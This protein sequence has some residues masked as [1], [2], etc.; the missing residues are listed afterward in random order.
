MIEARNRSKVTRA[1]SHALQSGAGI[2]REQTSRGCAS[3]NADPAETERFMIFEGVIQWTQAVALQSDRVAAAQAA[4]FR[5]GG[6]G[7]HR[8]PGMNFRSECDYFTVAVDM[9]FQFKK[10]ADDLGLFAS[11]DF[12]EID[13]VPRQDR[14]D[15]R[16]KRLHVTEYFKPGGESGK[17]W[18]IETAD[19]KADASATHGTLI[20]GRLDWAALGAAAKRLLSKL[21]TQP[22]PYPSI[23]GMPRPEPALPVRFLSALR[24][25]AWDDQRVAIA[26]MESPNPA[27]GGLT[28]AEKVKTPEGMAEVVAILEPMASVRALRGP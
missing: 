19:F 3:M 16:N 13:I 24:A 23:P 11:I 12:S 7:A 21:L 6:P 9:L 15:V 22:I 28:P 10:R 1:H 20:G 18:F 4:Q 26:W 2:E 17:G 5:P 27:L 14:V 8:L 25:M